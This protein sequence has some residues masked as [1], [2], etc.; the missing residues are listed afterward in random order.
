M[1]LNFFLD[2]LWKLYKPMLVFHHIHTAYN[3]NILERLMRGHVPPVVPSPQQPLLQHRQWRH[4]QL[5]EQILIIAIGH[6]EIVELQHVPPK[7]ALG[8]D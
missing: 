1:L 4:V 3:E 6:S 5:R 7:F 8:N 2:L